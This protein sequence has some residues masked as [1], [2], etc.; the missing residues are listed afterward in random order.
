M[1]G[2]IFEGIGVSSGS[3]ICGYLMETYGSSMAFFIFGVGAIC[4]GFVH[5]FVQRFLDPCTSKHGKTLTISQ[6]KS[7]AHEHSFSSDNKQNSFSN[8]IET[9]K[10]IQLTWD[11]MKRNIV[12]FWL[13]DG[14]SQFFFKKKNVFVFV[15][16]DFR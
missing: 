11:R 2:A 16:I 3:F 5:Y 9:F 13:T 1:V 12:K 10:Q 15:T 6:D 7:Q 8:G 14:K 4:M